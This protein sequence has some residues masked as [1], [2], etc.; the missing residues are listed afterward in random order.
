VDHIRYH[1][2]AALDA[3]LRGRIDAAIAQVLD[4]GRFVLGAAGERFEELFAQRLGVAHCVG[5]SSGTS[6]LQLALRALGIGPGD[7]VVCPAMTFV[8]TAA[9]I[10]GTGA[11]PVLADVDPTHY[12]IDPDAAA[13]A[14]SPRTAAIVPVHLYGQPAPMAQ[15]LAVARRHG[16][17]VVED[18]AQA[19]GAADAIGECG[20]LG[21]AAAFS[22]FP[23]KNLGAYG[24]AG[25]VTTADPS[26]AARVRKL[27][28]WGQTVKA[29]HAVRGGNERLDE[30][31]AAVLSVK[32]EALAGS[33]AAR[34]AAAL[35]YGAALAGIPALTVPAVR[36]GARH[37]FHVYALMADERDQLRAGLS[38]Q[39]VETAVHYP[40][41]LH[42]QPCFA[43]WRVPEGAHPVS[44][45]IA[46]RELSLPCAAGA[47]VALDVAGR[48]AAAMDGAGEGRRRAAV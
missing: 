27:R 21:D 47:A 31:Q 5:T 7:E 36:E 22:F 25:A 46:L 48:L 34:R 11:T 13:A 38:A 4:G 28:D 12:T 1:D 40:R 29:E 16:L 17:A 26:V 3:P 8:A 41:P 19:H 10:E 30:I 20:T 32:L 18:A 45:A 6:A 39:G 44:E 35:A 33:N 15:I 37:V 23:S 24:D 43:D 42:L 2:L 9:A 14:I